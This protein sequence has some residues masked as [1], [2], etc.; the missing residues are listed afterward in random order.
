[1]EKS[2][3][4]EQKREELNFGSFD[5]KTTKR[6]VPDQS[7][8]IDCNSCQLEVRKSHIHHRLLQEYGTFERSY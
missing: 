8:E 3:W 7:F 2:P 6:G 4:F 5:A 1:M